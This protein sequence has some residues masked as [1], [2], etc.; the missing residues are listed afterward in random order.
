MTPL[1][2]VSVK[3]PGFSNAELPNTLRK[4]VT[5][6]SDKPPM[7]RVPELSLIVPT[8]ISSVP[9]CDVTFAMDL[10]VVQPAMATMHSIA[11]HRMLVATSFS[12]YCLTSISFATDPGGEWPPPE[13]R[14]VLLEL[15][16]QEERVFPRWARRFVFEG[17]RA[18]IVLEWFEADV[19]VVSRS[20]LP[21]ADAIV[22]VES[23]TADESV[24][25]VA[26]HVAH[27]HACLHR[28][29]A[30]ADIVRY[31]DVPSEDLR[32][33]QRAGVRPIGRASRTRDVW[34]EYGARIRR[35]G[36]VVG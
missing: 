23:I 2:P 15:L 7:P 13:P 19:A 5:T 31:R 17:E 32:S 6:L 1:G 35:V 18:A 3:V 4:L 10:F 33:A 27:P 12:V 16:S 20:R 14:G 24:G 25:V 21:A 34:I 9:F 26:E 36:E 22:H 29:R 8:A 28:V 11:A 30:R